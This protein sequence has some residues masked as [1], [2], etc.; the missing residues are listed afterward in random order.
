MV[1]EF[2]VTNYIRS[3]NTSHNEIS[4][5]ISSPEIICLWCTFTIAIY[6]ELNTALALLAD[7]WWDSVLEIK[8][9]TIRKVTD[10]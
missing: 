1:Y 2:K 4:A 3:H 8:P 9:L 7:P 10:V 6:Y 5:C